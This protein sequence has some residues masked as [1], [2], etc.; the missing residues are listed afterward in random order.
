[1]HKYVGKVVTIIYQAESGFSQRRIKVL[2]VTDTH[3]RAYCLESQ[4]PRNFTLDG[5]LAAELVGVPRR[6]TVV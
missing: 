5:I 4:A 1:M 3:V 2:A 6:R